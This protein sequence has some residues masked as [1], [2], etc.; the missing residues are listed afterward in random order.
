MAQ[1]LG[2]A[3]ELDGISIGISA[4]LSKLRAGVAESKLIARQA[5]QQVAVKI[6][7]TVDTSQA[8][9]EIAKLQQQIVGLKTAASQASGSAAQTI[10]AA[11]AGAESRL[12]S[13]GGVNG[14]GGSGGQYWIGQQGAG[15]FFRPNQLLNVGGP[16]QMLGA[17]ANPQWIIGPQG[18]GGKFFE[19]NA[20]RAVGGASNLQIV[21]GPQ[22]MLQ[23]GFLASLPTSLKQGRQM[24]AGS[25]FG[26]VLAA[27]FAVHQI[28]GLGHALGDYAAAKNTTDPELKAYYADR[29]EQGLNQTSLGLR[30][31]FREDIPH[32]LGFETAKDRDQIEGNRIAAEAGRRDAR[33]QQ[34]AAR[35]KDSQEIIDRSDFAHASIGLSPTQIVAKA[36]KKAIDDFDQKMGIEGGDTSHIT[37]LVREAREALQRDLADAVR[38]DAAAI[39]SVVRAGYRD[40]GRIVGGAQVGHV[41]ATQGSVAGGRAALL[42]SGGDAVTAITDEMARRRASKESENSPDMLRLK[43]QLDSTRKANSIDKATYEIGVNRSAGLAIA[44]S[45]SNLKVAG[46]LEHGDTVS[47]AKERVT[48][49]YQ[50]RI[51]SAVQQHGAGS[52]VVNKL[53]AE[54]VQALKDAVHDA[55]IEAGRLQ[56]GREAGPDRGDLIP[57]FQRET[58]RAVARA[59]GSNEPLT[60]S[61]IGEVNSMKAVLMNPN[62]TGAARLDEAK[63]QRLELES[64]RDQLL[65]PRGYATTGLGKYEAYGG[66]GGKEGLDLADAMK[67]LKDGIDALTKIIQSG[68]GSFPF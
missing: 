25:Q 59:A 32:A 33:T 56:Y 14:G 7:V 52:D 58:R 55:H 12:K 2:N 13:L 11:L 45:D 50:Q 67:Q 64:R 62:L 38:E 18:G 37:R 44:A 60:A 40:T 39:A 10:S 66:P 43:T 16:Q 42:A 47:A 23:A 27:G 22:Q 21:G 1:V 17:P 24:L 4:D 65:Q 15:G 68:G 20:M 41:A 3:Q 34:I 54:W 46:Y 30:Q 36:A 63:T 29:Y 28:A 8:K 35:G 6:P 51:A 61:I 31:T 57:G 19:P 5:E 9:S 53:L 26:K 48:G 49:D